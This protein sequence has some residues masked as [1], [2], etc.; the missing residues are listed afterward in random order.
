MKIEIESSKPF[1]Q[2]HSMTEQWKQDLYQNLLSP[3]PQSLTIM[4]FYSVLNF[5]GLGIISSK[6]YYFIHLL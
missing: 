4:F 2:S 3:K 5:K 6:S 1:A